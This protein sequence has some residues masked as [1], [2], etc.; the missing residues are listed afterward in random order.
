MT[1]KD[2]WE[3]GRVSLATDLREETKVRRARGFE[4]TEREAMG[5]LGETEG[6]AE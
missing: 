3:W 4:R 6:K 1:D 5:S 2:F